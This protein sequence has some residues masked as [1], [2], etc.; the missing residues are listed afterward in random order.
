MNLQRDKKFK[1]E[2]QKFYGRTDTQTDKL[3]N[4]QTK[5]LSFAKAKL[6]KSSKKTMFQRKF[7]R[8]PSPGSKI[9][10]Q[11]YFTQLVA[12]SYLRCTVPSL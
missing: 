10:E 8:D 4:G 9:E 5:L 2:M 1:V 6:K 3:T 12:A 7:G 11:C